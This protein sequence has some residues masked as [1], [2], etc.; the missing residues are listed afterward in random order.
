MKSNK[1]STLI[2]A[3]VLF[4]V[5]GIIFLTFGL[6]F[7]VIRYQTSSGE[8]TGYV[9]AI[10]KN[11]II[12]KTGHAY[13]KTDTM[14]SQEDQYCVIDDAVYA[15]LQ[16]YAANKTHVDIYY[17]SWLNAGIQNCAAEDAIITKVVPLT[18]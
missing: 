11:G 18:Q 12:F 13:V 2:E 8:H 5:V 6:P 1:G 16:Q 15:Q 14:S 10:E 3:L 9:T 17:V 4:V 7:L